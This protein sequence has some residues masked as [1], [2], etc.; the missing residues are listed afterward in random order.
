MLQRA[1]GFKDCPNDL[2]DELVAGADF[3]RLEPR[4]VHIRRGERT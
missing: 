4:D 1:I 2:L 3:L